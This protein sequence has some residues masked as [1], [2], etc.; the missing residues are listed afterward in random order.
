MDKPVFEYTEFLCVW[1]ASET[2]L[3]VISIHK[4]WIIVKTHYSKTYQCCWKGTVSSVKLTK[5]TFIE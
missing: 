2:S 4:E 1:S 3:A 5:Y